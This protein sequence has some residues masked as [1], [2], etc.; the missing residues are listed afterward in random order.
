M[1]VTASG[2][3][4][5]IQ[6]SAVSISVVPRQQIED[7]A[8]RDITDALK[9]MPGENRRQQQRHQH[10]CMSSKSTLILVDGKRVDIRANRPN[11]TM[12]VQ[13]RVMALTLD[14]I[15][16]EYLKAAASG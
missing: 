9:D 7:K 1:V 6:D 13:A 5:K 14:E 2:F 4:Q 16:L 10:S 12:Q 3:Q 15:V 8:H 11:I